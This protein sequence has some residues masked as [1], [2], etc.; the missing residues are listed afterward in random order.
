MTIT[1][2]LGYTNLRYGESMKKQIDGK[3]LNQKLLLNKK[4]KKKPK[5]NGILT[6]YDFENTQ[7]IEPYEEKIEYA[8]SLDIKFAFMI[9]KYITKD[10]ATNFEDCHYKDKFIEFAQQ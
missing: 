5:E 3:R 6:P 8:K 7:I 4:Q 10:I 2:I 1:D 9:Y